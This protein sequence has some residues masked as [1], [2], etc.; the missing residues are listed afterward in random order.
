MHNIAIVLS[1]A[2][3]QA[4]T[5]EVASVRRRV[6]GQTVACRSARRQICATTSV[7]YLIAG[8]YGESMN[9]P[10]RLRSSARHQL[11]S[12]R[13]DV[14]AKATNAADMNNFEARLLL[15]TAEDRFAARTASARMA[16]YAGSGE[17]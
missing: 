10:V 7:F 16:V 3:G 14:V 5:F 15:R 2:G 13:Y 12:E 6:H 8:A 17:G 11:Q 4:T 9:A 1:L